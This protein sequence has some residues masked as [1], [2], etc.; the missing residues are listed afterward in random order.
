MG[1][2]IILKNYMKKVKYNNHRAA[3]VRGYDKRIRE[4]GIREVLPM[5]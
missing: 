5:S 4:E 1:K 2:T 3:T